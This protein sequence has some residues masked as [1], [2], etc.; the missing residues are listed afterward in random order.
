MADDENRPGR[1]GSVVWTAILL[2]L[3]ALIFYI[4]IYLIKAFG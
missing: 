3:V 2:G 1:R 4:G